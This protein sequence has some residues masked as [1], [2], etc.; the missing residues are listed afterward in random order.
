MR[1][2][3]VL[4][5]VA[6]SLVAT[7][8]HAAG[9]Q[10]FEVPSDG[11]ARQL[12]GAAWYPCNAPK[13]EVI[14]RNSAVL[15]ARD[16]P[17][18][19]DKLPLVVL[20]HGRG[21]WFGG[22]DATAASLAD[23]GFVVAA[24]DHPDHNSQDRNRIDSLSVLVERPADM[25]RLVDFMLAGWS[26]ATRLDRSRVGFF[27]FSMGGYTGLVAVGG[28]PDFRKDLPGCEKSD[29]LACEQLRTGETS[30]ET[31]GPDERIRVAVIVDP[32][33]SIFFPADSLKAIKVPVQLWSSDPKLS[34]SYISGCCALGLRSRLPTLPEFHLVSNGIH[35]SFLPP[36]SEAMQRDFPGLCADAPG[37]NRASFHEHFNAK[38]IAFM[39]K[40]LVGTEKP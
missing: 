6:L 19:G 20:S 7:I 33:P 3:E 2:L 14:V 8:A 26:S 21:G 23:A 35:F 40:H 4:L 37:F 38:V 13:Q 9:I 32:G 39:R 12:T 11:V 34:S 17:L 29:F 28:R 15:G 10:F 16:C 25:K 22:H 18:D 30:G 36:C 31:Q 24:I 5:A 1:P 27:G